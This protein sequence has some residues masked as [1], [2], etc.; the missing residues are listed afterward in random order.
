MANENQWVFNLE[1]KI[2]SIIKK[3]ALDS[4]KESYPNIFITSSGKSTAKATF[5]TVLIH[6]MAGSE[7]GSD[8]EGTAINAVRETFQID[9]T[10]NTSQ[11]DAKKVMSVII[12]EF[13]KLRFQST[14]M[15]EFDDGSET[16]RSTARVTRVIGAND[17]L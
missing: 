9:V 4:L 11:S 17:K 1:S 7:L 14:E 2:F 15:P 8:L 6:E 10:T 13:K 3:K 5:P 12:M 16:Y